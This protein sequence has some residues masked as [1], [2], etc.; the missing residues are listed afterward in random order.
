MEDGFALGL[1]MYGVTQPAEIEQRLVIYEKIRRSRASMIQILSNRGADEVEAPE[2]AEFL[3][4]R[5]MPSK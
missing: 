5:S 2:I 4:G 3:D 1:V